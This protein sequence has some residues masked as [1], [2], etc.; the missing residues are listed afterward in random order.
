[1]GAADARTVASGARDLRNLL[2][3][4]AAVQVSRRVA[5]SRMLQPVDAAR[6]RVAAAARPSVAASRTKR[7]GDSEMYLPRCS[8]KS[9]L[10]APDQMV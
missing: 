9:R 7:G 4:M 6:C 1:M 3:G 8:E 2:S 5:K 10:A